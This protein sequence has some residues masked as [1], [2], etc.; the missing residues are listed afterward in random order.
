MREKCRR[1]GLPET[2]HS[3]L[4]VI[5]DAI[6]VRLVCS[7][8]NDVYMLRDII[9]HL[10]DCKVVEEKDYIKRAKPNGYR[11]YHIVVRYRER[12]Y[13][14]IQLRTISMDS[15]AAL[16]H[17]LRYK[18]NLGANA[19]LIADELKRCSDELASTD[20]SMQTIRDLIYGGEKG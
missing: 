19:E 8:I 4:C 11:S 3:A 12:F 5:R 20:V 17:Q 15:W 7:F 18:K 6:G 1:Y 9:I 2:R 13:I 10:P 16:E 14:E